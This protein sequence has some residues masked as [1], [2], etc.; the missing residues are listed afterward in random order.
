MFIIKHNLGL[1]LFSMSKK[2][3]LISH[4]IILLLLNNCSFDNKSGIWSG[5][6]DERTRIAELENEQNQIIDVTKI[7]SSKKNF[8]QEIALSKNITLPSPQKNEYW[9]TSSY[10]NQNLL[11]NI[12]LSGTDNIFLK[13]KI[14]KNKFSLSK[15]TTSPLMIGENLIIS[16]DKGT[17]Y[18]IDQYGK[19]NWKKNIYKKIYKKIY[20]NLN[21]VIN[22]NNIFV[23][24]NIGFIYA[25]DL[26]NGKILWIKNHGVP[27]R[28]NIKI[29]NNKIFLINQDNRLFCLN[30]KDGSK[31]WDVRSISSFIKS[32]SLLSLAISKFGNV[33]VIT[34][35][36]NL[37]KVKGN[38]GKIYWSVNISESMLI[39]ATDF[40][41]TS[42][43]VIAGNEIIFSAGTSTYSYD[44]KNGYSNWE[45]QIKSID[46]P[47]IIGENVF[48]VTENGY[49]V[50]IK[51][52]TGKI[53]SSTNILKIL[54]K[55]KQKTK[56]TGFII[57]SGKL[58]SVTLNGYLIISSASTG[59]VE[60][61][62]KIGSSVTSSPIIADGKMYI[63]SEDS[64]LFGFN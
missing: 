47:I 38:N 39:D 5:E 50:I 29:F 41:E 25:I 61:F 3:N 35:S 44:L 15:V 60:T 10:N 52:E 1:L 32:Q 43:V 31:I 64:K 23:S 16:D 49:F 58:Y 14:G 26:Y 8:S 21:F 56:V 4:F 54:K 20:K 22:K 33:I 55:K 45:R 17:I 30:A 6:E 2:K 18:Y 59:K 36:G 53:I 9:K 42:E 48:I 62:K 11:G 24:D 28:S 12:Y 7:Y 13:K 57:G 51:K 34:S 27:L 19:I 63:L 37:L 46:A 40:F